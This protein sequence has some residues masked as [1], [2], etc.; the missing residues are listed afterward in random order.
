MRMN[1]SEMRMKQFG[2]LWEM[3][4]KMGKSMGNANENGKIYEE[5]EKSTGNV[6][7]NW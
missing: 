7:E 6:D 3:R 5:N 4:S 1:K 2:N